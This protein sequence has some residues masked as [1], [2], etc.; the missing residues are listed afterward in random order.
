MTGGRSHTR[1]TRSTPAVLGELDALDEG[2][3]A[4]RRVVGEEERGE[5]R[6]F[7]AAVATG[8]AVFLQVLLARHE[9]PIWPGVG[10]LLAGPT[11]DKRLA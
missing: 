7:F 10:E 8:P 9:L 2:G 5:L 6:A 4:E 3:R 11:P 1:L